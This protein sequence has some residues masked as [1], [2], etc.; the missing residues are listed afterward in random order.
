MRMYTHAGS[1]KKNKMK[2][3][4]WSGVALSRLELS[5]TL[6][7]VIEGKHRYCLEFSTYEAI[8]FILDLNIGDHTFQ[9]HAKWYNVYYEQTQFTEQ[10][11][12]NT[13]RA[14]LKLV[15]I[16]QKGAQLF[17]CKFIFKYLSFWRVTPPHRFS[18]IVK[19][20]IGGRECKDKLTTSALSV[21]VCAAI[22]M[23]P[24]C[25]QI[26][27]FHQR[28]HTDMFSL[29]SIFQLRYTVILFSSLSTRQYSTVQYS[30]RWLEQSICAVWTCISITRNSVI[31]WASKRVHSIS[32]T[33]S[34]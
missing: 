21:Y 3:S 16:I 28:V 4:K 34:S 8:R 19:K 11:N 22:S 7:I 13:K 12:N 26:S 31:Q 18:T 5:I 30:T 24:K 29:W 1:F 9:G 25:L 32:C 27:C 10:H 15:V 20:V 2:K 23:T 6:C 14:H 17:S 33:C